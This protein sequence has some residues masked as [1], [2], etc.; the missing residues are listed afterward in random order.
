M[1]VFVLAA[2][3]ADPAKEATTGKNETTPAAT[4]ESVLKVT[5]KTLAYEKF[6]HFFDANGTLE[7]VEDAFIS[8][9]TNGQIK[10][11]HVKEGDRVSAGQLLVTLNADIITNSI[12]EVQSGLDLATTVFEKRKGLWDKQIG[13]EI[14]YLQSKTEKESLEN[15]LKTLKAQLRLSQ[16]KAPISG[17][18]DKIAAKEGELAVPG[19]QLIQLV[20]LKKMYVNAEVS[21]AYLSKVK[22]GDIVQV[23]FPSYPELVLDAPIYRTGNV[24]REQNRTFLVKIVLENAEEKLKPNLMAVIKIKDFYT[25][26]AIVV[27]SIIIKNDLNGSYLYIVTTEP[28]NKRTIAK[29]MYITSGISEGSDTIV[30]K[31]LELGQQVIIEGYNLV[32]SGMAVQVGQPETK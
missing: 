7:A 20:N 21:E 26:T 3:G 19:M 2:C 25:D 23:L 17:I 22:K 32:K 29:K 4:T 12:A 13:S 15:R 5:V 6:E 11:I 30:A 28:G 16:I 8:P 18:V 1:I 9:E 10:K 14:Q 31:G 27:P 24:V